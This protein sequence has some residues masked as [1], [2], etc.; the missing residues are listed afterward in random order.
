MRRKT[1]LHN[2]C[3]CLTE[4]CKGS[5]LGPLNTA[6]LWGNGAT[7]SAAFRVRRGASAEAMRKAANCHSFHTFPKR[8]KLLVV[9]SV[10]SAFGCLQFR[11]VAHYWERWVEVYGGLTFFLVALCQCCCLLFLVLRDSTPSFPLSSLNLF[12]NI[13]QQVL[14]E[15]GRQYWFWRFLC[16]FRWSSSVWRT[17]S[18]GEVLS[19]SCLPPQWGPQSPVV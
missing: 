8:C 10:V 1:S 14:K 16:G 13:T 18:K 3:S 9:T 5:L 4:V 15:G 2:P 6:N 12:V 19:Y 7:A 11:E 17:K